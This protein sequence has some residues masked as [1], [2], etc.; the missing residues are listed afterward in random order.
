MD[1]QRIARRIVDRVVQHLQSRR[2][3]PR[4]TYR[5][6]L[7]AD[8][9]IR[10]TLRIVPYLQKL[11]ISHLY[12]SSLVTAKPGSRHGY[13]VVDHTRLNPELGDMTDLTALADDLH[14]RGMGLLLDI[15]ANHMHVGQENAWWN[16]VLENG[17][18]SP[19]SDYFDIAWQDT[20]REHL[21]GK[22]L[23][24]IL[25][26]PYGR[27]I[28][29][30]KFRPMFEQGEIFLLVN[31]TRLPLAPR[32]Y[33]VILTPALESAKAALGADDPG[34][35][36][37]QS[38]LGS[39]RHL[40][41][42]EETDPVRVQERMAEIVV[43][44]R[45][46]REMSAQYPLLTEHM[47]TAVAAL[48]GQADDPASF[49]R[50]AELLEGQAYRPCFWRVALDEIN[51]RRF[52]DVNDL[53][54]LSTERADVFRAI[55]ALPF[56]WLKAGIV[57]GFRID[58]IDGL[59]DPEE[60]LQRL[61]RHSLLA[62]AQQAL[63]SGEVESQGVTWA[64]LEPLV[65]Q[66]FSELGTGCPRVYVLVEKILG[67]QEPLPASWVC[68]GTTGYDVLNEINGLFVDGTQAAALDEVYRRFTNNTITFAQLAHDAK[69]QVLQSIMASELHMLAFRIDRLAQS[70]WYTQDFTLNSLRHA[71]REIV[72]CFPV[73]RTYIAAEAQPS[74][75]VLILKAASLARRNNPL[76]GQPII[77]FITD[78]L[79]LN[80]P[81]PDVIS[82]EYRQTQREIAGRF[83]QL[84]A[85]VTAKGVEDTALYRF[86]RLTSLNEVG[87]NPAHVGRTPRELHEFLSRRAVTQPGALTPLSTHDTKRSEDVRAR[88]NVLSECPAEWARRLYLW[89]AWNSKHLS[90]TDDG[91]PVPDA[92]EEYLLYQ[93]LIGSWPSD[94]SESRS[95]V[96]R[97]RIQDYMTKVIREAKVHSSWINPDQD[98]D[99]AVKKFVERILDPSVSTEF[100]ADFEEFQ[101]RIQLVGS[102]NSL[103]QTMLRCLSPGVP[104]TYQGS[105]F[106]DFSLVDPDNRRAVDY[107]ARQRTLKAQT[108]FEE[109][110]RQQSW[111][112]AKL[113]L[114]KRCLQLRNSLPDLFERGEYLPLAP[115]GPGADS[116]FAFLRTHGEAGVVVIV[117]R[118]LDSLQNGKDDFSLPAVGV[119]L[120]T[121]WNQR[122]WQSILTQDRRGTWPASV[123][124]SLRGLIFG[125]WQTV[126]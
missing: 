70:H 66:E 116:V 108:S 72:A 65:D 50:L 52:F 2:R 99:D 9:T 69:V 31:Q 67:A 51:Y 96:Y 12:V 71:L 107:G 6:Q 54:A 75:R 84:T 57:D 110:L 101:R 5:L 105:E 120:P 11:G 36:E 7:Y 73:Y 42:R 20:Q 87:G 113:M 49:G 118:L 19:Y 125:C 126:E 37:M 16:D 60:Y 79:L 3:I 17:P 85:P 86:N 97:K 94:P 100:L 27:A 35:L 98:Y 78:V 34:V 59:R 38:I 47:Q 48:S 93:T 1:A 18:A 122:N 15:V 53:A 55:H 29:A 25:D 83:Q 13:D 115:T 58:H 119:D 88:I 64:E 91:S 106:F 124:E 40:P 62:F 28:K 111:N 45:R 95:P 103:A 43:I 56:E 90:V 8:F 80:D 63:D 81:L 61:Q 10:D 92:N 44:K 104:D 121:P 112:G 77:Q 76:L 46:L 109:L 14:R 114:V 26:E 123:Q 24:P 102:L 117:P 68:D 41:T 32:T 22:V 33:E 21:R 39:V 4:S 74:D 89:R 30:G 23:L 82:E